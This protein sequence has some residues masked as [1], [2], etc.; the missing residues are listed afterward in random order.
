MRGAEE[1]VRMRLE[2]RVPRLL[3]VDLDIDYMADG[4][5]L[6]ISAN[7]SLASLDLRPVQ[8]LVVSVSGCDDKRVKAVAKACEE[9]GARRVIANI[10]EPRPNGNFEVIEV[11][12]TEGWF[13]WKK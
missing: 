1:L 2:G 7:D 5:H 8:G 3:W 9:N 13:T 11:I 6:S 4:E 12:D 10:S